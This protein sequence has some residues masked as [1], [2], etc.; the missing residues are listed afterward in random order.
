MYGC[1]FLFASHSLR[2]TKRLCLRPMSVKARQGMPHLSWGWCRAALSMYDLE[3]A[4][5]V[6]AHSQLDPGEYLLELQQFAQHSS[7]AL[8]QHAIDM[9]LRRYSHAMR[10]LLVAGQDHFDAAV[11]LAQDQAS[12][13]ISIVRRGM[14]LALPCWIEVLQLSVEMRSKP[15]HSVPVCFSNVL[16]G[17]LP[18]QVCT[19]N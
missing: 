1:C 16:V 4:Y 10:D 5:M 9:H 8:R 12:P 11:S 14:C 17:L 7:T 2:N 6:V 3:L 15:V 13:I 18:K 19:S